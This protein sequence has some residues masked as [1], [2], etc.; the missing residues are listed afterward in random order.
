MGW[1]IS[2]ADVMTTLT[3]FE[4]DFL[5][6]SGFRWR[7]TMLMPPSVEMPAGE[8]Q[9][10]NEIREL[11]D[12][13]PDLRLVLFMGRV[14]DTKG[15]DTLIRAAP[16]VLRAHPDVQFVLAGPVSD[17]DRRRYGDL[18][19]ALGLTGRVRIL[20]EVTDD[21]RW[22]LYRSATAFA[23]PSRYEAYGIVALEAMAAGV[24]VVAAASA[25][26]PEVLEHGRLG[27]LH[28]PGD[29]GDLAEKLV[30]V[31]TD[32]AEAERLTATGLSHVA[33]R[34]SP[35]ALVSRLEEAYAWAAEGHSK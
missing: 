13:V 32:D 3:V 31:L 14:T 20:G 23:F 34:H 25:A 17:S 2:Q 30:H 5:E 8:P 28:Q 19:D 24:P 11:L 18:V 12:S 9:P 21:E 33:E 29:E 27:L 35:M 7:R 16:S 22:G 1:V 4:R 10:P 6:R 15:A 26:I